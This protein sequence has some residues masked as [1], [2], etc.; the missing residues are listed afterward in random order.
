MP[1]SEDMLA[2]PEKPVQSIQPPPGDEEVSVRDQL[3]TSTPSERVRI[4]H[5]AIAEREQGE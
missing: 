1:S 4:A 2:L 5:E 3:S